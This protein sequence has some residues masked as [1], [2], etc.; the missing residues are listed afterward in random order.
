MAHVQFT[1]HL[2]RYFPRLE[3]CEIAADTVADVVVELERRHPGLGG[4]ITDERG[5]LRTHV[6]I[7]VGDSLVHDREKL[8]DRLD[9]SSQVF[10]M[11]ALSGG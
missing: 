3:A 7:Y 10:V 2:A 8:S 1:R 6:N 5:R 9:A 4:Y 11:Q